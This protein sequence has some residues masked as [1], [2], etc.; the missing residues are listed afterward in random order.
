MEPNRIKLKSIT[1]SI[2]SEWLF[3]ILS[4][5]I[6]MYFYYFL[7]W[8]SF[9]SYINSSV[10][11]RYANSGYAFLEIGMQSIIIGI[12]FCLVNLLLNKTK[13]GRKSFGYIIL[14]KSVFYFL[15]ALVSQM[16][17]SGIYLIFDV[18]PRESLKVLQ[19]GISIPLMIGMCTYF[20][21]ILFLI[22]FILQ[23]SRK[24]GQGILLSMITGK[25]HKPRIEQRLFMFL[26][27]KD[28]TGNAEK[29]G[30]VQYSKLIQSC[31][32]DLTDLITR[33]RANVY[34]YVGDEVVLTWPTEVGLKNMNCINLYFAYMQRL[35]D[36]RTYYE[37]KYGIS[38]E[39]KA[40]LSEGKI[41]V[42]EVGDLKREIA[43]HGEVLITAARLEKM[44]N[45]LG[46]KLL[47][48]EI[49]A[50]RLP[51]SSNFNLDLMGEF[52][53]RGK[54]IKEKVFGMTKIA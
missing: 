46:Q 22:N 21:V 34:Q 9:S 8:W 7:T 14:I 11:G 6:L 16:F 18:V 32:H 29:M 3:I 23:I 31:F 10:L 42:T 13:L 15:A 1:K 4:I 5:T 35:E 38:P 48:T 20:I 33:Y 47:I 39:F 19:S 53:L 36:Q 24:F 41:T 49:I 40:G 45:N 30:H 17:V 37:D 50:S 26:D 52:Q 2:L 28:S 25:Y 27:M 44:C 51:R 54:D 12:I 43:Y